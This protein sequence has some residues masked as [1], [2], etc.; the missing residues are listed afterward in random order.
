MALAVPGRVCLLGFGVCTS[1]DRALT[2]W[3]RTSLSNRTCAV[4]LSVAS[5]G[6]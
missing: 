4:L 3:N 1:M 2:L 5:A 6:C